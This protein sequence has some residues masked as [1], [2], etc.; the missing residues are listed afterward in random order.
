M[1]GLMYQSASSPRGGDWGTHVVL[2]SREQKTPT[3]ELCT[4]ERP[5][6]GATIVRA[7]ESVETSSSRRKSY[8]SIGWVLLACQFGLTETPIGDGEPPARARNDSMNGR[9]LR[10]LGA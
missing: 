9:E 1:P 10:F 6:C 5:P 3:I 7:C 2:S 4:M 8:A